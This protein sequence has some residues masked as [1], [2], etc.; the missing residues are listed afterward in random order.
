MRILYK[1]TGTL[2]NFEA[3]VDLK[4][5]RSRKD[6]KALLMDISSG[7]KIDAIFKSVAISNSIEKILKNK[8]FIDASG[9]LTKSG[10]DFINNPLL[11]ENE[12][13]TY[14][15]D[16]V[17]LPIGIENVNFFSAMRRTIS[18]E[19]R[20]SS[21]WNVQNL[22]TNN[23]F[24]TDRKDEVVYFK[25]VSLPKQL[26]SVFK[27][28]EKKADVNIN[29]VDKVYSVDKGAWLETGEDLHKKVLN[30]ASEVLKQNPY[31]RFDLTKNL[32]FIDILKDFSD[33]ELVS[34]LL[35]RYTNHGFEV[36]NYPLCID[37][38]S[39]AKQYAYLFMYYRLK[40]DATYSFK[41]MDEIFQNEVLTK[42]IFTDAVKQNNALLEFQYDYNGFKDN[43]STEK[44]SNLSYKLRVLEEFLDLT[45]VDNE[46][47]RAKNYMDIVTKFKTSLSG[48]TVNHLYMVMGYPFAKNSKTKTREMLEAFKKE[49]TNISIVKKGN[50]QA[51]SAEIEEDVRKMGVLVKENSAI[52]SAF[53]DRY[54]VFE[55]VNKTF[56]VYL[57]TCEIGQFFNPSTN[58]PLGS[59][60]KISTNEITKDNRNLIQLVKE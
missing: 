22:L 1:T 58:Q 37:N 43:L 57:V 11:E 32:L 48:S 44:F 27:G 14:S 45:I 54:L 34:G 6:F 25:E 47:S 51:E 36:N 52:K 20:T 24:L 60:F 28:E 38:I 41:E 15:I 16:H 56:E 29:L 5:D 9:K 26:K 23:Q 7:K 21:P 13:G 3:K 17:M 42:T 18:N 50:E 40:D 55:L 12:S 2:N 49:Y 46:F 31:G 33:K 4:L 30:Y 8:G 35:E 59:I 53:H 19:K 39:M 10:K